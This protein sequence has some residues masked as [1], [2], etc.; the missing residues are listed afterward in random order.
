ML[1]SA[2][3]TATERKARRAGREAS[4]GVRPS[5]LGRPNQPGSRIQARLRAS[6]NPPPRYPRAKLEVES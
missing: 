3:Q 6:S 5:P 4:W 1:N 2:H